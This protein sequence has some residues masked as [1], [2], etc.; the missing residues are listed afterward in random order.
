MPLVFL[1]GC[2]PLVSAEHYRED[3]GSGSCCWD[4]AA[5]HCP[6]HNPLN[7]IQQLCKNALLISLCIVI[8]SV[9]DEV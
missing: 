1:S 3:L 9:I 8:K 2:F 7:A 4:P 5:S 6:L